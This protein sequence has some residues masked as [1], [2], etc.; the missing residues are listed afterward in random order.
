M[1]KNLHVETES[2]CVTLL[3]VM[4]PHVISVYCELLD[5]DILN[6]RNY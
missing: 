6:V 1:D 2:E 3:V 4:L 5:Y